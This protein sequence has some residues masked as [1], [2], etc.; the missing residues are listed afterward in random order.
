MDDLPDLLN[1]HIRKFKHLN[2][3]SADIELSFFSIDEN[4]DEVGITFKHIIAALKE[5]GPSSNSTYDIIVE[6]FENKDNSRGAR[7]EPNGGENRGNAS[8]DDGGSRAWDKHLMDKMREAAGTFCHQHYDGR[9]KLPSEGG[10]WEPG[11]VYAVHQVF[12]DGTRLRVLVT[13]KAIRSKMLHYMSNVNSRIKRA[14]RSGRGQV[15]DDKDVVSNNWLRARKSCSMA[16]EEAYRHHVI[17]R[18]YPTAWR[19][20]ITLSEHEVR[21]IQPVYYMSRRG[22][23]MPEGSSPSINDYIM[24]MDLTIISSNLQRIKVM[25]FF[26]DSYSGDHHLCL[27]LLLRIWKIDMSW[28]YPWM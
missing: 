22:M 11:L 23:S 13:K 26:L 19:K 21:I 2:G 4:D 17:R 3:L 5:M 28:G 1:E 24:C 7:T 27:L 9:F 10:Y 20:S 6:A 15:A 8:V 25:T 18:S 16:W 12:K 14:Q